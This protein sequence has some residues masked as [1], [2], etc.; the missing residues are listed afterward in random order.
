MHIKFQSDNLGIDRKIIS[1]W[2][3][4]KQGEKLLSGFIWPRIRTSGRIL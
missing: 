4:Q 2:T 1:D 3:L